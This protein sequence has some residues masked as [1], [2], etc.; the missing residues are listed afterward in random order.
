MTLPARVSA[1]TPQFALSPS[2]Y[3]LGDCPIDLGSAIDKK[4][5]SNNKILID[6]LSIRSFGYQ[7]TIHKPTL[8]SI[9]VDS[10]E[11]GAVVKQA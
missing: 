8:L 3:F 9:K 5:L 6:K 10:G 11:I 1:H 7:L 2:H 4:V